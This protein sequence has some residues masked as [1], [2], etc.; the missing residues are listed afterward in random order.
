M[1]GEMRGSLSGTLATMAA[2][3]PYAIGAKFGHPDRPVYAL[4]GDGAM[5]MSNMAEL[6]TVAKYWRDWQ[7]PR[8][9][10]LVLNN[11]DLNQVT[12][13][14]RAMS[15]DPK[16]QASQVLPPFDYAAFAELAGLR[17]IRVEKP[18]DLAAA[19]DEAVA[20]RRPTV[21]DVVTDPEIPPLP[22]HVPLK[23]ALA[24]SKAMLKGDPATPEIVEHGAKGKLL[25]FL[26]GH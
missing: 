22:P 23:Q 19:W 3:V 15:G 20:E 8:W 14:Q 24:L 11:S 9:V 5:Q 16:F 18:G 4:V 1:R 7:D 10:C 13:E 2:A 26:P 25:E 17:G 12:W 6:L 21:V